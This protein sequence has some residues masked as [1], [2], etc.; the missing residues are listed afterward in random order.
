[1]TRK[2]QSTGNPQNNHE[3]ASHLEEVNFPVYANPNIRQPQ[4]NYYACPRQLALRAW[5]DFLHQ[6]NAA[7]N[8]QEVTPSRKQ[9]YDVRIRDDF[10][11][12][13]IRKKRCQFGGTKGTENKH[14]MAHF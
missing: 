8:V 12:Q 3:A 1:M 7:T 10:S 2:Q 6:T 14:Q 4:D 9:K 13:E 11:F 5:R